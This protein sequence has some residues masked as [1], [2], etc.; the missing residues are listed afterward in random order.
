MTFDNQ[1]RLRDH[2]LRQQEAETR[3][4]LMEQEIKAAESMLAERQAER[5]RP[6][7]PTPTPAPT[8]RTKQQQYQDA[9]FGT[10]DEAVARF[11]REQPAAAPTP[12]AAARAEAIKR[13]AE[14]AAREP[15]AK[16]NK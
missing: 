2:Q 11:K 4:C 6:A 16:R 1:M 10:L 15:A 9:K 12:T 8:P 5:Q 3:I 7:A 13:L 14:G